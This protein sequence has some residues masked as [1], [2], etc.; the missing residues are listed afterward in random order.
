MRHFNAKCKCAHGSV[1]TYVNCSPLYISPTP[2]DSAETY[3]VI[4][5]HKICAAS[6]TVEAVLLLVALPFG[7]ACMTP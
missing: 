3:Y 4:K 2:I 5:I 7:H 1:E 6:G